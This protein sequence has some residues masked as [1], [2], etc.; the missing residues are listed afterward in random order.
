MESS[1]KTRAGVNGVASKRLVV[2]G[3]ASELAATGILEGIV[4]IPPVQL[5]PLTQ[6]QR[7]R[8]AIAV[9]TD[10]IRQATAL[11]DWTALGEEPPVRVFDRGAVNDAGSLWIQQRVQ[12]L[13]EA[14]LRLAS[15]DYSSERW[16]GRRLRK[17]V[18]T[19][20]RLAV[21]LADL[22]QWLHQFDEDSLSG[23]FAEWTEMMARSTG[24]FVVLLTTDDPAR[25]LRLTR[26][27]GELWEEG[28]EAA[29]VN[30][31]LVA[32]KTELRELFEDEPLDDP[33]HL[34]EQLF[35]VR[36][37]VAIRDEGSAR[38]AYPG[39][40]KRLADLAAAQL[41]PA[42]P[43]GM[44][45]PAYSAAN[46][47]GL[48]LKLGGSYAPLLAN[49]TATLTAQLVIR[50]ASHHQS[51]TAQLIGDF[52]TQQAPRIVAAGRQ[53]S[54]AIANALIGEPDVMKILEAYRILAEGILRP[55]G[56]L[57]VHLSRVADGA[58][59]AAY[60]AFPTLGDFEAALGN[61]S[62][63][64]VLL[65]RLGLM[66]D[67]RNYSAH[68]NVARNAAGKVVFVLP[69]GSFQ[70]VDIP[71]LIWRTH[72]LRSFLDGVD[73][74]V[75]IASNNVGAGALPAAPRLSMTQEFLQMI[76]TSAAGRLTEGSVTG[77][78][79]SGGVATVKFEGS[80]TPAAMH[81]LAL[82]AKRF[83]DPAIREVRLVSEGDGRVLH[84]E[85]LDATPL[86]PPE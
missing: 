56:S 38:R 2:S 47:I 20:L 34:P 82:A 1:L 28:F 25:R 15:A 31:M 62:D 5:P 26:E 61:T 7:A 67:I 46:H 12:R 45:V 50:A 54:S 74:A 78:S 24:I 81:L 42:W 6:A 84:I 80:E 40:D 52:H 30:Q 55:Y 36:P 72:L 49:R 83:V 22:S 77:L 68:E 41:R 71:D 13:H 48:A 75:Q 39:G 58:S 14:Q 59:S 29:G 18:A 57:L 11:A 8:A 4:D 66:I 37:Q 85:A 19:L 60:S 76:L 32:D 10:L 3:R 17:R 53:H 69:D 86:A 44:F 27:F 9:G 51:L 63:E 21:E 73:V 79:V 65:A 33:L 64:L 43:R 35:G 16:V 70:D 23:L